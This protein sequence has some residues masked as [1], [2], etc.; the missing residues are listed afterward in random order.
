MKTII[1]NR[2]GKKVP[3]MIKNVVYDNENNVEKIIF[4]KKMVEEKVRKWMYHNLKEGVILKGRVVS[5]NGSF[6]N[7]DVRR[8]SYR[9]A[10]Y[11]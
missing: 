9:I 5:I 8:W 4:S 3:C 11:R 10:S 1:S 2:V 6:A 7:L